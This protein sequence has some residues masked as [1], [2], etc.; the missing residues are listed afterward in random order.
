MNAA[1]LRATNGRVPGVRLG[2]FCYRKA[3]LQLGSLAGN[4]FTL[5]L[6]GIAAG[7]RERVAEA[8]RRLRETGF[9]NYFG[10]QR[11]GAGSVPTHEIGAR[12][13]LRS[14]LRRVD[15]AW[16]VGDI[17]SRPLGTPTR[18]GGT[19]TTS[20]SCYAGFLLLKGEWKEAV[21][22]I[23]AAREDE[24]PHVRRARD[25]YAA[26]DFAAALEQMP[27]HMVAERCIAEVCH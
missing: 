16:H 6:R 3:G 7:D 10:L 27:R 13:L 15:S 23:M 8:A 19:C 12:W 11:F 17:I 5:V 1:K 9:I 21:A 20:R 2:S 26:G 14:G 25:S 18:S 22:A 4:A 24:P